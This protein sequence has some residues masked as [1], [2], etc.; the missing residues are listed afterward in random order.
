MQIQDI[1]AIWFCGST[2]VGIVRVYQDGRFMYYI[3]GCAGLN[4]DDDK[5]YIAD[6]G[7]TFPS[8]VGELL[9]SET[10]GGA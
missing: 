4:E 2:N 6:W 1:D 7:S 10:L 9:F 3:G 8:D 5:Q